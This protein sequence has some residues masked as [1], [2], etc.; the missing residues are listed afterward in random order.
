MKFQRDKFLYGH[1]SG[2]YFDSPNRF[3]PHFFYLAT[4]RESPCQ[5]TVCKDHARESGEMPRRGGRPDKPR[6]RG[7]GGHSGGGNASSLKL[8]SFVCKLIFRQGRRKA[9]AHLAEDE[10]GTQDVFKELVHKL[11]NKRKMDQE[12]TEPSCMDWRAERTRLRHHLTRIF[13]EC[14]FIPRVGELVLWCPELK[15]EI[16]FN[17]KNNS[18]Q[19]YSHKRKAFIGFPKWRAGTIAQVPEEPVN[20]QDAVE[21][22]DKKYNINMSGFRVETFPDPNDPDDKSL[23]YQYKYVPLCNIR[24]LSYW[25]VLLQN[26]PTD[27][28]HPSIKF[29]LTIMSSFSMLDKYYFKGEWPN[30]FI[31]CH[32][33]YLGSELLV[34]GDSVRLMPQ[35]VGTPENPDGAVTDILVIKSIRLQLSSCDAE[36]SSPQLA[37]TVAPRIF[38]KVYTVSPKRAYREPGYE[39]PKALTDDEVVDAFETTDMRSYGSWYPLHPSDC[40]VQVSINQIIGRLYEKDYMNVVFGHDGFDIDLDGVLSGRQYGRETDNRLAVGK[41]WFCGDYRMEAL[42]LETF[43][44]HE[45]GP[46]DEARDLKMWRANLQIIDGTAT[47]ADLRAAKIP[48]DMG[49]PRV[50]LIG[51]KTTSTTF[52]SVGKTS[53]MVRSALEPA[54]PSVGPSPQNA[55]ED[56]SENDDDDDDES[57]ELAEILQPMYVRGGTEESSGGDYKPIK[58]LKNKRVKI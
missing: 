20:L 12:V 54:G 40:E 4:G 46:Y 26:F 38:G 45:V 36:L 52:E 47:P 2:R 10:E 42:A 3:W 31:Y 33:I 28:F 51:T 37:D 58:K 22:S 5:C 14:S 7:R 56:E 29:A 15:G 17:P 53:T 11:R 50:G 19:E 55:S 8:L 48:R 16:R 1:I 23:S 30:A 41:D 35:K 18:F 49:R 43:N 9:K 44:G 25:D 6:G 21:E 39:E 57:D 13:I 34:K 24:P 27:K 32:G